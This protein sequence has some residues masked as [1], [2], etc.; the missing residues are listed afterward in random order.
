MSSA[1]KTA[2]DARRKIIVGGAVEAAVAGGDI[3][4]ELLE[5]VIN[6]FVTRTR[7][8]KFMELDLPPET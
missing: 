6:Q 4:P 5:R 2:A 8:R 7:E 3:E 1:I